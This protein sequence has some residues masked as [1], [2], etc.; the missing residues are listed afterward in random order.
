[1]TDVDDSWAS[2][3]VRICE[4]VS[5]VPW[6]SF[7]IVDHERTRRGDDAPYAQGAP[8]PY[9]WYAEVVSDTHRHTDYLPV[10]AVWLRSNGWHEPD[11]ST[12]NWWRTRVPPGNIAGTLIEALQNGLRCTNPAGITLTTGRFPTGPRGGTPLSAEVRELARSA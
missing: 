7:V 8:G 3:T 11:Q 5:N 9:G 6:G 2:V 10:D 1:M 12:S 4:E